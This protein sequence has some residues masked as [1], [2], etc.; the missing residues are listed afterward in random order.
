MSQQILIFFTNVIHH[1]YFGFS[2]QF[3]L[4]NAFLLY[5]GTKLSSGFPL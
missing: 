1:L 4:I 3:I 2:L 5:D